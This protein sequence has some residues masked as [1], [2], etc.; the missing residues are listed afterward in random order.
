MIHRFFV[1]GLVAALAPVA[2]A[3]SSGTLLLQGTVA[4]VNAIV[5]TPN[6]TNNTSLPI[7]AGGTA[8]NVASVAET[9]NDALGYTITASSPTGGF[10]V[11]QS[12]VTKKTAYKLSYNGASSVSLTVPGVTVKT[13]STLPGLTTNTSA[14]AV[15]VTAFPTA[16]AGIYQDTVT[17]TIVAN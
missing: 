13:V 11:N 12:D 17:L 9:S 8:I 16:T 1:F 14:A 15:D 7:V 2:N 6:A 4:L 10:L 3:A 5:I